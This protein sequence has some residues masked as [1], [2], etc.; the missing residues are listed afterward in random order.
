MKKKNEL[1][2]WIAVTVFMALMMTSALAAFAIPITMASPDVIY[3]PDNHS[4]IQAAVNAAGTGDTIIVRNGTY[5]ENVNVNKRLTVQSEN[6]SDLTIVQAAN[7]DGHVF[8]VTADYVNISGFT[9]KGATGCLG[10]GIYLKAD[11]CNISSNICSNNRYGIYPYYSNNNS[12]SNNICSNN[13]DGL[14]LYKSNNNSISSNICSNNWNRYGIHL[15]YSN[16]NKLTGNTMLKNGIFIIGKSLNN[17]IHEIDESNI[18]NGKP[19]YYWKNVE[20][21]RIPD[22]AGQV[23]LANCT[24]VVIENQNLNEGTVGIE[25]AFSSNITIKNNNC[26]SNRASIYLW[27]SNS[28]SISNN[29]CSN[30][31]SGIR[32]YESN[33]NSI[34]KNNC[35][36]NNYYGIDLYESNNNSIL[37]NNCFLNN[38][39]GIFLGYSNNNVIYLNNFINNTNNVYSYKSTNIWNSTEK[40]TYTYNGSTYTNYLGDYWNDYIFEGND[41]NGDGIGDTPH[42]I[43]GDN[44]SYPLMEPFENYPAPTEDIFDTGLPSNPYPSI[45]GNH[46]GTIKPNYTVIA[47][48]L[49]TYPCIGTGGHTEYAHIWNAT[50]NATATWE[51]YAGD[52]HNITF[53]KTV[54]LLENESYNY[55]IRTGSYPQIH[56]TDNLGVANG[57]GTITCDKFIDAN[58]KVYND[59]IPAIR[60]F[61]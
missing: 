57:M 60:L 54:V 12:I 52:W 34:S 36:S 33:N 43:D 9:V 25:V 51:G 24:D 40:I 37:K 10:V 13:Y 23:I 5:T 19:V 4:T 1:K 39:G 30:S 18:V 38:L 29:N 15:L 42:G 14:I 16:N 47:T 56:H 53:D 21:G 55:I 8:K 49:Y 7:P 45:M 22:D 31:W 27:Y 2:I 28:S 20:G 32:L 48:K 6:G 17:Y 46:T 11:Y 44:D 58:G 26:L 41:T 35:L 59:G 3:V 61:L 50:W